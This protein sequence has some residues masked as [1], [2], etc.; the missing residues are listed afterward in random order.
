MGGIRSL[1]ATH[2][3][4]VLGVASRAAVFALLWGLFTRSDGPGWALGAPFAI[5]AALA[6]RALFPPA[7]FR[8]MGLARFAVFFLR[9]SFRAGAEVAWQAVRP[10]PSLRP[11]LV[12]HRSRLP[13]GHARV[14]MAGVLG[15][16]PGSLVVE[17]EG[18]LLLIHAL[19]GA[20]RLRLEINEIE[21]RV[22]DLFGVTPREGA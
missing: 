16:L 4:G 17:I 18:D 15:L 13:D 5:L 8:P 12:R 10:R 3:V 22:A 7:P 21:T 19:A 14:F 9:R 2:R 1:A 6:S 11:E 20:E